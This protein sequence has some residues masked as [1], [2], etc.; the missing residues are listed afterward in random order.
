MYN[1]SCL[2]LSTV[3]YCSIIT[4][5]KPKD[6]W[7]YNYHPNNPYEIPNQKMIITNSFRMA[8]VTSRHISH[9]PV[10]NLRVKVRLKRITSTSV[11]GNIAETFANPAST[12]KYVYLYPN[13]TVFTEI[14]TND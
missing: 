9:D 8:M 5:P 2:C 13:F 3:H 6:P 10:S 14:F 1:M 4:Q 12:G 7:P 11:L